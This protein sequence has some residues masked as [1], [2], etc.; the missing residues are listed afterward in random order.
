MV[1]VMAQKEFEGFFEL[2]AESFI[3]PLTIKRRYTMAV[4]M[5][6]K[7]RK[8]S[9]E[10]NLLHVYE[11]E[12]A[13]RVKHLMESPVPVTNPLHFCKSVMSDVIIHI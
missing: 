8:T 7:I 1:S 6:H 4:Y 12:S 5:I 3:S 10:L 2:Q 11:K 9:N 13:S